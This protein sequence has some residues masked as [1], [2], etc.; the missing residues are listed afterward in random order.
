MTGELDETE[1]EAYLDTLNEQL[2]QAV[3]PVIDKANA[4]GK[5]EYELLQKVNTFADFAE[6]T[7]KVL[8]TEDFI[9]E[10]FFGDLNDELFQF[11]L[12][13]DLPVATEE[14]KKALFAD[15]IQKTRSSLE[16]LP[17]QTRK[18]A[19]Q[20][21]MGALP[22]I[23]SVSEVMEMVTNAIDSASSLEQKALIVDKVGMVFQDNHYQSLTEHA[24]EHHHDDDCGCGH[25]HHEHHHHDHDCGCGHDHHEHHHHDHDCGCGH[26]HHHDHH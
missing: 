10:C 15:F 5:E 20:T 19:M 7:Q 17:V 26:D 23:Y 11:H 12:P 3:E 1:R 25:D 24:H 18:I 16:T 2:E 9:R 8:M 22:P 6:D 21:L 14:E 13:E 4:I